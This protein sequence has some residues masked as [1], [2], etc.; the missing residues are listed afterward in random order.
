MP[1]GAPP[2]PRHFDG[3]R[4]FNPEAP[5]AR[6]FLD[7]VR[8]K[9]TSRPEPSGRFV[10]DVEPSKPPS[11]IEG[12]EL[13][14][15]LI[16]HSTLLLQQC[17]SHILTD[18]IWSERAS[19]FTSIGPRRRRMPGVLW[20]DL[21][22]IDTV[23]LSHNH[24]DHLDLATLR[25]L[26]D[27]GQSQFIVPTGVARLLR[28][29]SIGPVH[30]LDWGESLP[31]GRTNIHSVPAL[32][33]SARGIFDRNRTLWCGYVIET[34]GRVVYFA[35]DTA[36]GGHFGRIRERFG[37]PRLALLPIGAYEPRWFMSPV[38]MAPDEAVRAHE[39][40]AA[41]T[42]IAIHHGTFQLAD[43]GLD[44]PKK[45][46]RACAPSDSFLVLDNGQSMTIT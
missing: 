41:K 17:D 28:S 21:P 35:R 10:S 27:R 23:L 1:L 4:F 16:N 46:L 18:P 20:E 2:I 25:R 7:V 19:P 43:D 36:F 31:F 37:A 22:R 39:I 45:W 3:K 5:Q 44:T 15:T 12:T 13:R 14:V 29:R 6:G 9:L 30:E 33:F 42:S 8:W 11:C 40:L 34:A 38:H 26:A 24:Y 32:H